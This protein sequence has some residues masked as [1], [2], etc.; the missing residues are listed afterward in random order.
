MKWTEIPLMCFD[1]DYVDVL[2]WLIFHVIYGG[3]RNCK[4]LSYL[5]RM[6]RNFVSSTLFLLPYDNLS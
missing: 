1:G 5:G 6:F 4:I 3:K 2:N